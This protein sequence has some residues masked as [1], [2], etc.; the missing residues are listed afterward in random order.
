MKNAFT[1]V[2]ML[3]VVA[4]I[5]IVSG[6]SIAAYTNYNNYKAVDQETK[7]LIDVLESAKKKAASG[8]NE[9]SSNCGA[10]SLVGY[11][12]QVNNNK[13]TLQ[14]HCQSGGSYYFTSILTYSV[15]SGIQLTPSSE[16]IEYYP[17]GA[18]V[19]INPNTP[20]VLYQAV[21]GTRKCIN[22]TS[23]GIIEESKS[24]VCAP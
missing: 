17:L 1:L 6:V 21:T 2:E 19:S 4:M 13:Y 5:A 20:L 15:A 23:T 14:I 3:V 18:A 24:G 9:T 12:V 8:D 10:G 11:V 22:I 7:R 16:N